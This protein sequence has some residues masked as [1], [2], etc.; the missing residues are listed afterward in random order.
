ML[1]CALKLAV[2]KY[3]IVFM[4]APST[5][6]AA[7]ALTSSIKVTIYVISVERKE[8]YRSVV[9]QRLHSPL[10]S[11]WE[12]A[13]NSLNICFWII[14]IKIVVFH[15]ESYKDFCFAICFAIRNNV[16]RMYVRARTQKNPELEMW[17]RNCHYL[18]V[19]LLVAAA[20]WLRAIP[21]L[22]P[23]AFQSLLFDL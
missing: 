21:L 14:K 2:G 7:N 11:A 13:R 9:A 18:Q 19:L 12:L 6:P 15:Y 5:S 17:V 20:D 1:D 22:A 4:T 8:K 10:S 16:S 3:L 23:G